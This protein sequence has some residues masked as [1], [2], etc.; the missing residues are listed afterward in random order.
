MRVR[1]RLPAEPFGTLGTCRA[2]LGVFL[3]DLL[4]VILL[5]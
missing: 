5:R 3:G 2:H 1:D 4:W